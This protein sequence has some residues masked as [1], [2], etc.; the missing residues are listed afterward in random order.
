MSNT[1]DEC[2]SKFIKNELCEMKKTILENFDENMNNRKHNLFCAFDN[3]KIIMYMML[4]RSFDSQL[5]T[6]LQHIALYLA[7]KK[8]G[9][10]YAPNLMVLS[11]DDARE[12]L[13]VKTVSDPMG[14][15]DQQKIKW[16]SSIEKADEIIENGRKRYKKQ[17][18]G[19]FKEYFFEMSKE[20]SEEV[21]KR[22]KP[23][24]GTSLDRIADLLF[25]FGADKKSISCY[26][27]KAGGN[28]DTK[29]TDANKREVEEFYDLF[30]FYTF[31]ESF[32]ATCYNNMGEGNEPQGD[33]FR[34]IARDKQLRGSEFWKKILPEEYK[35][36]DFV[37]LYKKAFDDSEIEKDIEKKIEEALTR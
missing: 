24:K 26:E 21:H 19:M 8:Y 27:L 22:I 16:A 11:Y 9:A 34:K 10:E 3:K 29:N 33:I 23:K 28:L 2:L 31:R 25:I 14:R 5:G 7:R 17:Q 12:G 37:K 36:S 30:D 6:R 13:V 15:G 1:F 18:P 4:G 32:F 35:F 20:K